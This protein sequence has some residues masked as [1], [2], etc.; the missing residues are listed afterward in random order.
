MSI[1]KFKDAF[2]ASSDHTLL[3]Q[4]VRCPACSLVYINPRVSEDILLGGYSDAVDHEFVAQNP[5][6]I[7][8]FTRIGIRRSIVAPS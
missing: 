2:R 7:K 5:E 4:L 6:R 1:Q 3:D 8:T